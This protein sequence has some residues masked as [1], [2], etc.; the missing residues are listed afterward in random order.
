[1]RISDWSSD[2]CSS[3]LEDTLVAFREHLGGI[4]G[5]L[6]TPIGGGIRS[7]N[8]AIRKALDLYVCQRP[9]HWFEG[10]PSP[11]KHPEQVD[12]V[13]FRENTEDIYTGIEFPA[14]STDG[15]R[16]KEFL[17]QDMAVD[18]DFT[19]DTAIGIKTVSEHGS[20][21]LIK[22]AIEQIGRAHV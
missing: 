20:K 17:Q 15:Q 1:M 11:V 21:R 8:V 6:T 4:K 13:I 18:Y 16:V 9:T 22:A 12:M 3:D 10:V 14:G 19:A 7:L 5:P 2:V